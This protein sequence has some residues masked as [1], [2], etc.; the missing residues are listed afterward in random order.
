[1]G[2][3]GSSAPRFLYVAACY[4]GRESSAYSLLVTSDEEHDPESDDGAA[5]TI[6]LLTQASE[7][8]DWYA[9][10]EA[11]RE[12][13]RATYDRISAEIHELSRYAPAA[14]FAAAGAWTPA[15]TDDAV[16]C[17]AGEEV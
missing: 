11:F 4:D 15:A 17:K 6:R 10:D 3:T 2:A 5:A 8:R 12:G 1:M 14:V 13:A 16:W 7:R 9:S